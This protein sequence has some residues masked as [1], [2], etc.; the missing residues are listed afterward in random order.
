MSGGFLYAVVPSN[1]SGSAWGS[2]TGTLSDQTDLQTVLNTKAT[3]GT[4]VA[5]T[6]VNINGTNGSGHIHLKHQAVDPT[7]TGSSSTLFA[8]SNGN[9]AWLNDGLSKATLSANNITADRV[10]SVLDKS[11]TFADD[12]AVVHTNDYTQSFLFMGA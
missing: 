6:S 10:F 11:Y 9:L 7:S 8:D 3:E 5:F 2:I 1:N 4:A 12:S